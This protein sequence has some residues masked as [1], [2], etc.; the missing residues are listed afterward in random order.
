[1]PITDTLIRNTKPEKK[2]VRL[3]DGEGLVL[4][5][6][7]NGA[8]GW[9]F[10]YRFDN[11]YKMIS[12][13]TYPQVSL[14][15][16]RIEKAKN[17]ELLRQNIDP[18]QA[19][20]EEKLPTASEGR[21]SFKNVAL[22]WWANWKKGKD[23][24]YAEVV[25]GRLEANIFPALGDKAIATITT[26]MITTAVKKIA[27]RGAI[28]LAHRI[29][30]N[31]G[32]IMRYAIVHGLAT[33]NPAT[34]V[35]P[36]D[37]LPARQTKNLP[38]LKTEELPELL[39]RIETY[40][41][42]PCN[43]EPLTRLALKLVAITF[44]RTSDLIEAQW[45]EFNLEK[46]QW[47][48]PAERM[49]MPTPHIVPLSKQAIEVI[50]DIRQHTGPTPQLLPHIAKSHEEMSS[51]TMLFALYRMGYHSKMTVHGFRG[52]A[53]TI[54]H[55]EGFAHEHIELQ[56]AH[57]ERDK[58]SAAYNYALYIKPRT[59]MMQW[60]ADYL[61]KLKSHPDYLWVLEENAKLT[62]RRNRANLDS[63]QSFQ[64]AMR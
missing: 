19:R 63:K 39:G 28:D 44:V 46:A 53:S 10:R 61:D 50:K 54:L 5:I 56:L 11:K 42:P 57:Q 52:M 15:D 9:R 27:A 22:Q 38:R 17:Q 6:E 59:E 58:V 12:L 33:Y 3:A 16:A 20:R 34:A 2:T 18:A 31:C 49:K 41:L 62:E 48:I 32:Q 64:S 1:M 14:K 29:F 7:P 30:G 4:L 37:F 51:N 35:E 47:R 13:G 60:W 23:E 8:K 40:T 45:E 21:V 24:K 26:P 25:K 55:E 43:G 36:S